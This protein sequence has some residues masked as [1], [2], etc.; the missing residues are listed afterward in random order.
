MSTVDDDRRSGHVGRRV[1]REKEQRP[2]EVVELAEAAK[3]DALHEVVRHRPLEEQPTHVGQD[4][5][6]RESV[7]PVSYTHLTLP[8][9]YSV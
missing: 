9:I 8:T 6:R 5:A 7:H 4:V 2:V 1:G 3:R